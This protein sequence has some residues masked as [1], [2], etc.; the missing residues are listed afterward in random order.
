MAH[1]EV[2]FPSLFPIFA[3]RHAIFLS[4]AIFQAVERKVAELNLRASPSN[5]EGHKEHVSVSDPPP[6]TP[7]CPFSLPLLPLMKSILE[8]KTKWKRSFKTYLQRYAPCVLFGGLI[9]GL[10]F[11]HVQDLSHVIP[12]TLSP[13]SSSN[14]DK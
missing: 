13:P 14:R 2:F 3:V 6:P 1:V 8:R 10:F 11:V 12:P 9:L 4:S 7:F 5:T